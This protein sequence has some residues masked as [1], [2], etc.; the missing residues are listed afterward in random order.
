MIGSCVLSRAV[1][2]PLPK[3][4]HSLRPKEL[5]QLFRHRSV[6]LGC[7]KIIEILMTAN[8]LSP[9]QHLLDE[10][11]ELDCADGIVVEYLAEFR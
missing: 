11:R 8:G 5:H 6:H 7:V 3:P 10:R 9:G 4:F 2:R 1:V